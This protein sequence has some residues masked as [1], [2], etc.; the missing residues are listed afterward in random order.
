M[1]LRA[2]VKRVSVVWSKAVT[3]NEARIFLLFTKEKNKKKKKNEVQLGSQPYKIVL[4][5]IFIFPCE[6]SFAYFRVAR[7]TM[8]FDNLSTD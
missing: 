3:I 7:R 2:P 6:F 1:T 8:T 5:F 4:N